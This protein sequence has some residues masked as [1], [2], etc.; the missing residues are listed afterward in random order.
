MRTE[1]SAINKPAPESARDTLICII[2]SGL[3]LV[4]HS[5][6]SNYQGILSHDPMQRL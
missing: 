6:G 5:P 3:T 4:Y 2:Q 1:D